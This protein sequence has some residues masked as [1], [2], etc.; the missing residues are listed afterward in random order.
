M[1][2]MN[3]VCLACLLEGILAWGMLVGSP[4]ARAADPPALPVYETV[5]ASWLEPES[6]PG[7]SWARV[8]YLLWWIKGLPLP[9]LVTSGPLDA[10]GPAGRPGT[11]GVPGTVVLIGDR[12]QNFGA[13][14][15]AQFTLGGW[16]DA[17]QTV[18]VEASY[19][20]LGQRSEI[21]GQLSSG[22]PGSLPLSI[23]FFDVSA[24]VETS[25]GIAFPR[26]VNPFSGSVEVTLRSE[27]QGAETNAIVGL[28]STGGW[29]WNLLAGMR[30]LAL[31]EG[32]DF[33]TV[34]TNVPPLPRDIF[35]TFDRFETRNDFYGAQVGVRG[36]YDLGS[37]FLQATAKVAL[38][39]AH[40]VT[41][42]EGV[43]GTNDFNGLGAVQFFPGG[44]LAQPTNIGRF[45]EDRFAVVPE[46]SLR[47]GWR[48]F[49]WLSASVGYSFLYISS[50][51]R[52]G[53]QI[54][55]FINPTQS[56]SF[57]SN[58]GPLV[59]SPRPAFLARDSAFWAHGLS[60]S[61]EF[62]Y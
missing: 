4:A 13:F 24:G 3:K 16:A 17:E 58:I 26:A 54:D 41:Q 51:A 59:G 46:V 25:T 49:D 53:D 28:T 21:L 47:V 11:L 32:L 61:A 19:L 23:P 31:D 36:E 34:S 8:D 30:W 48:P 33:Y 2:A 27:L 40:Q 42:I 60:F 20:F 35:Q 9:P 52:P 44:Y 43:L 38:G 50:V 12:D 22:E 14:S 62:L 15:G 5:P 1:P 7:Q 45:N 39:L 57:F 56:P 10:V 6:A 29:R 18:G 37:L 55:H